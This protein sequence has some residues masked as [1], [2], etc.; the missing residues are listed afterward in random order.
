MTKMGT[1][2]QEAVTPNT[3]ATLAVG[4]VDVGAALAV[5]TSLGRLFWIWLLLGLQSFGG[6]TATLFLIRRA[7]VEQHRWLTDVD[8]TR[9]WAMVQAAPGINLLCMTILIGH[10]VRGFVGGLVALFGLMVPS[11]AITVVM[12]ALYADLRELPV[13]EAALR[14]M[15]PATVGLGLLLTYNMARPLVVTSRQEGS[16]SLLV[17]IFILAGSGLAVL[18]W[19]VPVIL[20]LCT[21]GGLSALTLWQ[22]ANQRKVGHR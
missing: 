3:T 22:H 18:L 9:D 10:R 19:Q 17:T 5:P 1:G 6:G 8:F 20:V 2:G 13:V 15:V 16:L 12:T 11:V 14:G 4:A 21:A 7:A